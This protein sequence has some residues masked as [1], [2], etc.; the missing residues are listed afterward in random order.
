MYDIF[1][2]FREV[3]TVSPLLF[4]STDMKMYEGIKSGSVNAE[5]RQ[6]SCHEGSFAM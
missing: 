5:G 4:L 3:F 1:L 2:C 6:E